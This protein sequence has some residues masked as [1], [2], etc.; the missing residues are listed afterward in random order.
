[1]NELL[2]GRTQVCLEEATK[3][4]STLAQSCDLPHCPPNLRVASLIDRW[5]ASST[6]FSNSANDVL[7]T[8]GEAL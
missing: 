2:T 4:P 8:L 5:C 3:A 1:M 7:L 6:C